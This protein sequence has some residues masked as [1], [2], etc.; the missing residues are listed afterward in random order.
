VPARI[1]DPDKKKSIQESLRWALGP[2]QKQA[3]A[4]GYVSIP[5][6]LLARELRALDDF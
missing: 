1:D 4:L 5:Q 2:G 6:A 3:A